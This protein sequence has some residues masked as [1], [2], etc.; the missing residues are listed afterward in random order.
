MPI[1]AEDKKRT[2]KKKS[3]DVPLI[4]LSEGTPCAR[5]MCWRLIR[6][7]PFVAETELAMTF[8]VEMKRMCTYG[9]PGFMGRT[10]NSHGHL[11]GVCDFRMV[12][13]DGLK[14]RVSDESTS[15]R[16]LLHTFMLCP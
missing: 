15:T 3:V 11:T 13:I 5:W 10:M 9:L 8:N 1:F 7:N 6:D 12:Q 4:T 14:S 2:G 16:R